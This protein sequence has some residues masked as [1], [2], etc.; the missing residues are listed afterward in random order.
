MLRKQGLGEVLTSKIFDIF[1]YCSNRK[2]LV[3]YQRPHL[4][5]TCLHETIES[6][7]GLLCKNRYFSLFLYLF[8]SYGEGGGGDGDG[9]LRVMHCNKQHRPPYIVTNLH[10]QVLPYCLYNCL[11]LVPRLFFSFLFTQQ[12][13]PPLPRPAIH[14]G[15]VL[16]RIVPKTRTRSLHTYSQNNRKYPQIAEWNS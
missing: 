15:P 11:L 12:F 7:H 5:S 10:C 2:T 13:T 8:T 9:V 4:K 16:L 3:V 6:H 14:P 1:C